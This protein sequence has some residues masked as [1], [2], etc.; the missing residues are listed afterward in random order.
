MMTSGE[1]PQ[2]PPST[3]LSTREVGVSRAD[4]SYCAHHTQIFFFHGMRR[5]LLLTQKFYK[6]VQ[7]KGVNRSLLQLELE[8]IQKSGAACV[9]A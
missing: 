3:E 2:H 9:A 6:T 7:R 8:E 4:P 5:V 1:L